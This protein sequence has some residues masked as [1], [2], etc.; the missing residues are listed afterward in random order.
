M[1]VIHD[2]PI[3]YEEYGE[4]DPVLCNAAKQLVLPKN[5]REKVYSHRI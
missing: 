2:I 4:G 5:K 3:Y 1:C